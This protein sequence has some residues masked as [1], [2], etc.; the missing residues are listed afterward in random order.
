MEWTTAKTLASLGFQGYKH[1]NEIKHY[2]KK[3]QANFDKGSTEIA[4]TG[5]SNAGKTNLADQLEGRAREP[6]Y[7]IA[8]ESLSVEVS[9]VRFSNSTKLIRVLPG[10]KGRR[11]LGEIEAFENN[12]SLEGVI[13]VVDYGYTCPRNQA[14]AATLLND[15]YDTI[16]KLRAANLKTELYTLAELISDIHKAHHKHKTPK[17]LALVVNKVDLFPSQLEEALHHYHP[18][19]NGEY[20]KMLQN[21]Q[22][23]L[24]TNNFETFVFQLS[25][26]PV[27]FIWQK[28]E[29]QPT[30]P[31]QEQND[32]LNNFSQSIDMIIR[33]KK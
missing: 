26:R 19:L 22:N 12:S 15:G 1:R 30:M 6:K 13:H 28:E 2:Y 27:P 17:W 16:E 7:Q 5:H 10:Q 14:A 29:I 23:S 9:A 24:G 8:N 31:A 3:F 18:S 33:S 4:V 11:T 32:M 21:L 25:A 20:G